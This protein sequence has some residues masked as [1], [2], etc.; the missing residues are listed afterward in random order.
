MLG[1]WW[2]GVMLGEWWVRDYVNMYARKWV[3][4]EVIWCDV[5]WR[6]VF[7][8]RIRNE[9]GEQRKERWVCGFCIAR[10]LIYNWSIACTS[11]L[12]CYSVETACRQS[13]QLI[14]NFYTTTNFRF[15]EVVM[16]RINQHFDRPLLSEGIEK[17]SSTSA[18]NSTSTSRQC[19]NCNYCTNYI[20]YVNIL[21]LCILLPSLSMS[22]KK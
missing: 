9:W 22:V 21:S 11:M 12:C 4:E 2:S 8:W 1:E 13:R 5:T 19:L 15:Y 17:E 7:W 14:K 6:D 18:S 3:N 20:V 16:R 10:L